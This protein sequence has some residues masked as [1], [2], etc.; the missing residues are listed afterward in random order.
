LLV[1]SDTFSTLLKKFAFVSTQFGGTI[2]DVQCDNDREFN[3]T[4]SR[5]FFTT[6]GVVLRMSCL[7]TSPQNG[8]AKRTL[9]TINNMIH[10]PLFQ[11]SF[12]VRYWIDGLH[13][14]TYLLNRIPS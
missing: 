3:N 1:K 13:T 7:F 4:S 9:H 6:H 10:S 8:N 11:A 2:K 5:A 12:P 14:A